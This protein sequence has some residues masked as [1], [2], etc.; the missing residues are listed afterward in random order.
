MQSRA[1]GELTLRDREGGHR[2]SNLLIQAERI[3]PEEP[4]FL[5]ESQLALDLIDV[6]LYMGLGTI[7]LKGRINRW[8]HLPLNSKHPF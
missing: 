3:S 2:G 7:K 6:A 1:V 8:M 5:T 4:H